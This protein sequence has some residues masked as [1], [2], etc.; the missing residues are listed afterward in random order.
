MISYLL[1]GGSTTLYVEFLS[2]WNYT[3]NATKAER[4][5]IMQEIN[6]GNLFKQK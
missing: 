2:W 1:L 3:I 4:L 6:N 5:T